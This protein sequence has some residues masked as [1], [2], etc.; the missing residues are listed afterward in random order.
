MTTELTVEQA[1]TRFVELAE[2]R[3]KRALCA[4]FGRESGLDATADALS[5]AWEH[6]DTVR[7]M[8][9]PQGYL[10]TVGRNRARRSWSRKDLRFAELF[11]DETPWIEPAL[12][13]ALERLSQKQRVVV[14]LAHGYGWTHAE[15][16]ETLGISV[17]TV[18]RHKE[19]AMGRLRRSLGVG[20]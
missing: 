7:D 4:A 13:G 11:A 2:P 5:Y 18:Q 14:L 17:G 19:R 1:F 12:P 6:W 8:E 15:I 9:N 16:A 10:W 20:E 3:L